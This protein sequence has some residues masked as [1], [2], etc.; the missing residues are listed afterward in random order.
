M[1]DVLSQ[2]EID[3]LLNALNSGDVV[4]EDGDQTN[5]A[6]AKE[7]DFRTANRFSREQ[8]RTF[9]V[10]YDTFA[11][12]F[13]TYL[14]GTLRV[15]CS[16]DVISVEEVKY[17]EFVNAMPSP[18]VLA[19]VSMPPLVGPTLMEV[20]PDVAYVMISRLLGGSSSSGTIE[21]SRS[22]TEI[23]LVLLERI[24][25]QCINLLVE[26]WSKIIPISV[27][28]ERIETSPQFAQIVALNE[29]IALITLNVKIGNSE[30][31]MNFCLPQLALEPVA[32][33]L[34]TKLMFQT[35]RRKHEPRAA[36]IQRRIQTTPLPLTAVFN[37]TITSVRDVLELQPGDILQLDHSVLDPLTV[38]V[39]HLSKFRGVIGV[40]ENRYAVR[41]SEMIREEEIANE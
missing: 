37:D 8:I 18:V 1:A 36:D 5:L 35:D 40:K 17:Q 27:M 22:F 32:K 24:I 4:P 11:R 34:S 2:S 38:K 33:Q 6:N 25:R 23:E 15:M 14:S 13:A 39:G 10:I 9:N 20:A 7:Y 41:I 29:T 30:G 16:A 12:L 3:A 26:S 19:I 21:I 31:F 28:L